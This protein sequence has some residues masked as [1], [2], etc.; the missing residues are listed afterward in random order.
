MARLI[1]RGKK[2]YWRYTIAMWCYEIKELV[3]EELGE[4]VEIIVED[5]ENELP[6]VYLNDVFVLEGVPKEEGYLLELIKKVIDRL[7][8]SQ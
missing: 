7:K 8:Y 2:N 4:N 5:S 1:I 6:Q 3:E